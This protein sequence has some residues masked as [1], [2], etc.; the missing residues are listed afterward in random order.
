[1]THEGDSVQPCN[2]L[3]SQPA[4][5]QSTGR[6]SQAA[7]NDRPNRPKL[8]TLAAAKTLRLHI[9]DHHLGWV[10]KKLETFQK[11]MKNKL[12]DP[13]D[14]VTP[15]LLSPPRVGPKSLFR[16]HPPCTKKT[17]KPMEFYFLD[18]PYLIRKTPFSIE[19]NEKTN[20]ILKIINFS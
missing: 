9:S 1:M 8:T 14:L 19:I 3:T 11:Q 20:E 4:A 7:P 5:Q 2:E 15:P 17:I 18:P 13:P 6:F 12:L 16:P 10:Q